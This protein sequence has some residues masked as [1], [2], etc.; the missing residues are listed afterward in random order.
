MRP[1]NLI[2]PSMP[3]IFSTR[4]PFPAFVHLPQAMSN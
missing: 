1:D 2:P 4:N 3:S